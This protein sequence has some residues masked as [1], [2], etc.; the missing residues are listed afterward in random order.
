MGIGRMMLMGIVIPLMVSM[1]GCDYFFIAIIQDGLSDQ[2]LTGA[3]ATFTYNDGDSRSDISNEYGRISFFIGATVWV[4]PPPL[5]GTLTVEKEGY[6]TW[7]KQFS[8]EWPELP[9]TISLFP[10][11]KSI[12]WL[13]E[14]QTG[15]TFKL[16]Q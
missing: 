7:S 12:Q 9:Y 8:R 13:P 5:S 1:T 2:P 16:K 3:K 14:G 15:D 6:Q 11:S 10:L 4:D